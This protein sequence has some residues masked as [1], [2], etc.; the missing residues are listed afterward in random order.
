M[1]RAWRRPCSFARITS[2]VNEEFELARGGVMDSEEKSPDDVTQV[3]LPEGYSNSTDEQ[4]IDQ[5][6][7][8]PKKTR[9]HQ[10]V[11]AGAAAEIANVSRR[12]IEL[13]IGSRAIR[14]ILVGR[15]YQVSLPSLISYLKSRS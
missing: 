4:L 2:R 5:Y 10:F 7:A 15:K 9:D 1:S 3:K 6:L 14:A 8:M 11:G 12:S 13:W